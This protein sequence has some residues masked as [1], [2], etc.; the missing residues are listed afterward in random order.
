MVWLLN[1]K[2]SEQCLLFLVV[3]IFS[4]LQ[5]RLLYSIT[6]ATDPCDFKTYDL[7][8]DEEV[9]KDEFYAVLGVNQ[10]DSDALFAKLD[11][12]KGQCLFE[13]SV[14]YIN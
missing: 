7:N 9:S 14:K 3:N 5:N 6:L 12:F 4:F 11:A 10:D 8:E 2:A 1:D 13:K